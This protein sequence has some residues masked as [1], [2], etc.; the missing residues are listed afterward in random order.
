MQM[1]LFCFCGSR[2]QMWM[3]L[4]LVS[5]VLSGTMM[6][7]QTATT[8]TLEL[9]PANSPVASQTL[10][11]LTATVATG[12][13]AVSPGLVTFCDA[14]ATNCTGLAVVGTAQLTSAGTAVLRL[15]PGSGSHSY[16]AVF[17]GTT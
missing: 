15:I 14:T 5:V 2:C 9:T 7:A 10:V 13:T 3:V 1:K 16:H 4:L 17:A 8:T 11:T 12:I 6:R